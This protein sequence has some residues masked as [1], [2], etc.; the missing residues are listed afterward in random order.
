[1]GAGKICHSQVNIIDE[2]YVGAGKVHFEDVAAAHKKDLA[3]EG[4]FHGNFIKY[5]VNEKEG[6]IYCLSQAPDVHS[7]YLSHK[8]AYGLVPDHIMQVTK[9]EE[10]RLLKGSQQLFLDIHHL[11]PGSVIPEAV[12]GVHKKDL[13]VQSKY[14]VHFIN[15]LVDE[16]N[17]IV[18]ISCSF[19]DF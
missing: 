1:M 8:E 4:K 10:A 3:T 19:K 9:G 5:R 7:I 12:A 18:T 14:G 17:G 2:H 16:Q 15:Y 13:A 6:K 11:P